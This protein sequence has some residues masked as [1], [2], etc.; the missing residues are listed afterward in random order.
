MSAEA[1]E[2]QLPGDW[3]EPVETADTI[4]SRELVCALEQ[5]TRYV[6]YMSR[7]RKFDLKDDSA[8]AEAARLKSLVHL[9]G[10]LHSASLAHLLTTL[11]QI[12]GVSADQIARDLMD[13]L[14]SGDTIAEKIWEW[15]DE[16][17]HDPEQIIEETKKELEAL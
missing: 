1:S 11:Q 9:M 14:E 12:L 17:G 15:A 2:P 5:Q 8:E 7:D 13:D 10:Y 4:I 16:R 6:H 3:P